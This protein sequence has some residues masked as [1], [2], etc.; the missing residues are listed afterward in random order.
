MVFMSDF[1]TRDQRNIRKSGRDSGGGM[2]LEKGAQ[3]AAVRSLE[4]NAA[5][6][7]KDVVASNMCHIGVAT[8]G[9]SVVVMC[10]ID[11]LVK[12][13]AG[14]AVQWMNRLW[15]LP[16]TAGLTAAAPGWT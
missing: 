1:L 3:L 15:D 6:R 8:N 7:L 10:T 9:D 4:V 2:H 12:G 5:P 14:G 11:N 16:E 13:A